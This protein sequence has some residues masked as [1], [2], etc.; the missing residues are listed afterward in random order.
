MNYKK[1]FKDQNIRFCVLRYF[2]WISDSVMIRFQYRIKLGMWPELKHP[3]RFT[4][5]LQVYKLRYRN[6][7]MHQCVDKYE[8]RKYV[9]SKGLGACL[10]EL[11]G[12]FESANNICLDS[13]PG[14]F[15]L[16]STLGS[17]GKNVIVV[18]DKSNCDWSSIKKMAGLWLNNK[19]IGALYGREWAYKDCKS[20]II[21]E[22]LLED[23]TKGLIDYKFFCFNGEP[24]F[25]YVLSDRKMG[26]SVKLGIYDVD[27]NKLD[28]YRCDEERE[29]VVSVK[30]HNFEG[31]LDAA[32]KLSSDFPHV[33][34]DLYNI[35]GHI[36]FGE[37]TFYDGSGYMQFDPDEFDYQ[38]GEYFTEYQ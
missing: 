29:I 11:Y 18:K 6:P 27:F 32:R 10:N 9:E 14:Q 5:K 23:K 16:K 12:V 8:V 21:I 30:P 25:L 35:D 2:S 15:V 17:G 31:M 22:R 38:F 33:R 37:L 26:E 13:L 28:A 36:Y 1:I 19:N 34:V 4:E 20:R 24:K 3:K 7:L